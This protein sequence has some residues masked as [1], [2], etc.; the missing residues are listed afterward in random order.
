MIKKFCF[1]VVGIFIILSVN[2]Q[3]VDWPTNS[4]LQ[5]PIYSLSDIEGVPNTF[6]N[7]TSVLNTSQTATQQLDSIIYFLYDDTNDEWSL[8]SYR[9]S[10]FY[11]KDF[12]DTLILQSTW[13][14]TTNSWKD[15]AKTIMQ[16]NDNQQILSR[17]FHL[18]SRS[19]SLMKYSYNDNNDLIE[20][21]ESYLSSGEWRFKTKN[22][23]SYNSEN[24]LQADTLYHRFTFSGTPVWR[25]ISITN[26]YYTTEGSLSADTTYA[27]SWISEDNF[28]DW[29]LFGNTDIDKEVNENTIETIFERWYSEL[30]AFRPYKKECTLYYNEDK[31]ISARINFEW[32]TE[33]DVW[34]TTN[35]IQYFYSDDNFIISYEKRKWGESPYK[36]IDVFDFD[37]TIANNEI[38]LPTSAL[39]ANPKILFHHKINSK[40]SLRYDLSMNETQQFRETKYYYSAIE[41]TSSIAL[42]NISN[43]TVELYPNPA[44]EYITINLSETYYNSLFELFDINGNKI[45]FKAVNESERINISNLKSGLYIYGIWD[46][47]QRKHGKLLIK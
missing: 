41:G 22:V 44:S 8:R 2:S 16:Y 40:Q 20:I 12:I 6:D 25:K 42:D 32:N 10:I 37:Y 4:G 36:S 13:D 26:Y 19:G 5:Q 24:V 34:D 47:K 9:L 11:D 29:E 15:R 35:M 14:E 27:R 39:D 38:L 30:N 33:L 45:L 23:Y 46:G 7:Q 43:V 18:I 17:E 1:F 31:D 28:G 21:T 3:T